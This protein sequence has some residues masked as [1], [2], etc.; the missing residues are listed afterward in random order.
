M[1]FVSHTPGSEALPGDFYFD[2]Q[3]ALHNTGQLFYCIPWIN[4]ELCLGRMSLEPLLALSTIPPAILRKRKGS[5]AYALS[6]GFSL[7]A[8]TGV[9]IVR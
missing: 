4:G 5:S 6:H 9:R 7:L 1:F 3:W 8:P 2:E